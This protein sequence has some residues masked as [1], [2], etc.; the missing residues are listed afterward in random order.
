MRGS[1][2]SG[3]WNKSF[4]KET[5]I[6][7]QSLLFPE[8]ILLLY[9]NLFKM[10]IVFR[11]SLK[12]ILTT[13]LGFGFGAV[14]T[15]FLFVYFLSKEEYGLVSYITSTATILSPLIA[16]GVHNTFI[17]YYFSYADSKELSKFNTMLFVLPLLIIF[18]LGL[19]GV[20][21]YEH[22][23]QWLSGE[24][25]VVRDYVF[26]IFITAIAMGYFEIFYSWA[27]VQLKTVFG[28]FL[29]EVFHRICITLLL[30]GVY[31]KVF[32]FHEFVWGVFVAYALRTL[33]M[34]ISS[35]SIKLPTFSWGLPKN[36]REI[37]YYSLFIVVSGS[38][39]NL[40]MDIDKFMIN[41]YLPISEI[42]IYN[43]AIF[44]ATVIA[45]PYRSMYQVVSPL[46]AKF[47]STNQT[48][49]LHE[50]YKKSTINIYLVSIIV[51]VLI[52]VNANQFY[53]LL[54]DKEY[55]LGIKVLVFISLVK[56]SD[57]LVGVNNAILF[58]S[59]YYRIVL[60]LGILLII[61]TI[62]LNMWLIPLYGIDGAGLSTLCAFLIYNALKISFVYRKFHLSPFFKE[63]QRITIF[64]V[65][66]TLIFY[67]WDFSISPLSNIVLKSIILL[68]FSCFV[69]IRYKLS[70]EAIILIKQIGSM[71][72]RKR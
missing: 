8:K 71:K 45:I 15:L 48:V 17:R 51:F 39:A 5:Y 22:M 2:S 44:T 65:V 64:G 27:R 62:V 67:F 35:F 30:L 24:N 10:G 72:N 33:L 23:V 60:Y 34:L 21:T 41:Q 1:S 12:N 13:Y 29:K 43:V 46:V 32:D 55:A 50:L 25:E 66:S 7:G 19:I 14:N 61:C 58:N 42:A 26:L 69:L 3:I 52:I 70:E 28:N 53:N 18:P 16:F 68:I 6:L 47:I 36:K 56:L 49:G 11:Q 59:K 38:V 37:F 63:T 31:Y 4:Q 9:H 20:F 54:P 57:S 40:L